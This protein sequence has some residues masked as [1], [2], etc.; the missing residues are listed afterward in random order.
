[1]TSISLCKRQSEDD[2]GISENVGYGRG[3]YYR[4]IRW[5]FEGDALYG[6]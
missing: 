3:I 2:D 6:K 4:Q 1:M 5:K